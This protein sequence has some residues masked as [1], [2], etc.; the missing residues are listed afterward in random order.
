MT[1]DFGAPIPPPMP[2]TPKK[3]NRG[4]ITGIIIAVVV[5]VCCCL[6]GAAYYL[7]INGDNIMHSLGVY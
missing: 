6:G 4:L 7:Y 5:L 1:Q 3:S 2:E